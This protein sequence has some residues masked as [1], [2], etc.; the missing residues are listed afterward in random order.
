[1]GRMRGSVKKATKPVEEHSSIATAVCELESSMPTEKKE[2]VVFLIKAVKDRAI[3]QIGTLVFPSLVMLLCQQKGIIPHDDEEVLKNKGPIN[4][5]SIERMTRGKDTPEIKAVDTSYTKK[6]KTKAET[7][8]TNLTVETSLLYKIQDIKKLA[9]SISNKKIRLVATL[10]DMDRSQNLFYA[11]TR[12]YNNSIV[13]SLSY[14][15][16]SEEVYLGERDRS[17]ESPPIIHVSNVEKEED[18]RDIEECMQR[19]DSLVEG[20]F[21]AG[22]KVSNIKD[23]VDVGEEKVYVAIVNEKA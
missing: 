21:L 22:Q 6:G 10:E 18:S 12:A 14:E 11:Y 16:S 19:I 3:R 9:N 5:A 15:P 1:M 8:G 7:T 23:E 4:E 20:D 17:V 2:L 13:A